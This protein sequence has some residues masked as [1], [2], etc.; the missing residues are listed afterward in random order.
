V[1]KLVNQIQNEQSRAGK[2]PAALAK[3]KEK[4]LRAKEKAAEEKKKKGN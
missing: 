2:S 3:E 1:Q 4:E